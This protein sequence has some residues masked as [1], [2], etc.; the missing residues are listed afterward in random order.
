MLEIMANYKR[1]PIGKHEAG[2]L[3]FLSIPGYIITRT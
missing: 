2:Q 3:D 1:K